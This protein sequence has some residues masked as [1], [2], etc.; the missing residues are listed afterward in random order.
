MKR[1]IL[2]V[3]L[4]HVST[5]AIEMPPSALDDPTRPPAAGATIGAG[6]GMLGPRLESVYLPKKGKAHVT[7][8][9]TQLAIG[10]EF[11]GRRLVRI[12]ETMVELDGPEGREKLYLTPQVEIVRRTVRTEKWWGR[13]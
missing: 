1:W 8:D 12:A 11:G 3:M 13:E 2:P 7:I 5:W 10:D 6:A 4:V 9:G